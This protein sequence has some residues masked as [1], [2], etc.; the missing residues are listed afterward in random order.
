MLTLMPARLS[1]LDAFTATRTQSQS[2]VIARF[3][4]LVASVAARAR[5]QP[6]CA[7]TVRS[8]W[9]TWRTCQTAALGGVAPTES[10]GQGRWYLGEYLPTCTVAAS[11]HRRAASGTLDETRAAPPS[12]MTARPA[13]SPVPLRRADGP[14]PSNPTPPPGHFSPGRRIRRWRQRLVVPGGAETTLG[15][16]LTDI[17]LPLEVLT[18]T[19]VLYTLRVIIEVSAMAI[20]LS[21]GVSPTVQVSTSIGYRYVL[22]PGQVHDWHTSRVPGRLLPDESR[23]VRLRGQPTDGARRPPHTC[24]LGVHALFSGCAVQADGEVPE[25]PRGTCLKVPTKSRYLGTY[26]T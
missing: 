17:Q 20:L 4:T 18:T 21:P 2:S 5:C 22:S 26:S 14:N 10:A 23:A 16:S 19:T 12:H 8:L 7:P 1:D 25:V 9:R 13:N 6:S 15:H 11:L 3:V 24:L